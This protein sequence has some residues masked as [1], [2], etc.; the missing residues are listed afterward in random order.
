M[1]KNIPN[2]K[3]LLLSIIF[4]ISTEKAYAGECVGKF[5]NPITDVC[6]SC[7]FPI[8]IGSTTVYSGGREDTSNPSG[9]LG[10]WLCQCSKEREGVMKLIPGIPVGFWEPVRLVDVTRTP[11]C[12]VNLGGVSMS[13]G[14]IKK[15]G[16]VS[17]KSSK[18]GSKRS[19]YQVHW[20]VYPLIYW[21]ELITDFLCLEKASFDV[22]YITEIDPLWNNDEVGFILN[23]EAAIFGN[24]IA[25]ASCG[26]DCAA[27]SA[28]FPND[29]MFWCAGCQGSMYPFT[30]SVSAHRSGVQASMLLTQRMIAKL[31]RSFLLE[32]TSGKGALCQKQIAPKIKKTQYKLQ[33]TYPIPAAKDNKGD[34]NKKFACNPLGRTEIYSG[35]GKEF[36]LLWKT[37][38]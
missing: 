16:T 4:L 27:A 24:P 36:R 34:I 28:G 32:E 25:Q 35:A 11:F 2:Y 17:T 19:F 13:K 29:Y 8:S 15:H 14:S 38:G 33:M 31:H 21:L 20:Y 18:D 37:S 5:L 1:I 23:P 26:V 12:L 6:W 9:N 3:V 30:G 7:L 22:A 10:P